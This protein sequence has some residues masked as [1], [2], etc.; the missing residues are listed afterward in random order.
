MARLSPEQY[1]E[2]LT[3]FPDLG[4]AQVS[5]DGRWVAWTWHGVGP[6]AD[7]YVV[8]VDGSTV[9]LC[10]TADPTQETRLV[11]WT[12]DSA[13]VIVAQ[14]HD[15][16]ERARLFRVNLVEPGVMHPLTEENP[17]YF[18]RGGYLHPNGRW[19]VYGANLDV[20]TGAEIEPTWVYRHDLDTGERLPLACPQKGG[21]LPLLSPDGT[22][23]LYHRKDRHAAG[24][25]LWLVDT[26][27]QHDREIMNAGDD[28]K[29][30]GAWFSDS[31]R[32]LV[33][34]GTETHFRVGVW[35]LATGELRW[36]LDDPERNIEAVSAPFRSEQIIVLE[37]KEARRRASWL[38]PATG[39]ETALA[40]IP[41]T[42]VPIAPAGEKGEWV[43]LYYSSRQP[44][45]LVR[46]HPDTLHPAALTS[47][48]RVWERTQLT[49][50]DLTA[51]EDFRWKSVDGMAIQGWLYRAKGTPQGTIVY[52]HGGPTWHHEDQVYAEIQYYV[53]QG[54]N[55]LDPNYRGSTGFSRAFRE[56]IKVDGWGGR[57]QDDIRT[58]IEALIAAGV[59]EPGKVGITGTS[60]G[61]YS[62]WCAITRFPPDILAASAPICGMTDLVVD[63]NTTR[64][65]LRPYSEE[66]LG[67][68]P[69]TAPERYRERSPIHFVDNIQ[70][71]LMIVQ[72]LQDPN[73]TPENVRAVQAALETAHIEY[74]LL[75]FDD[76]GHGIDRPANQKTLYQQLATFFSEAFA[77]D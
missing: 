19:L 13:A 34:A 54:F 28:K 1:L 33:R 18:V 65:D 46:F 15:G 55:V 72:G 3:Q 53:A 61:G 31:E 57:E 58:G 20:A 48:T 71:R 75:V 38:N 66:M 36:L 73:V 77:G 6:T 67:G 40:A 68:T 76:E 43:G 35:E 4:G 51:A 44:I 9:P 52:V 41:G 25:Q 32:V 21:Y 27:G 60:Y 17:N 12:P 64:P 26:E 8:P 24:V 7:V 69:D 30:L 42:L 37:D 22:H 5:R 56:A 59:A 11:S 29:V 2:E 50:D 14:D 74:S 63:Y 45:D 62:S 16:D 49:K 39:K 70:G 23:V 10:L 47:L